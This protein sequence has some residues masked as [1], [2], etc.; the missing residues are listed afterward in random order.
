MSGEFFKTP[1]L[2]YDSHAHL[3]DKIFEGMLN[4][5]I[6]RARAAGVAGIM[7]PGDSLDSS[8]MAVQIAKRHP[9]FLRAAVGLHPYEARHYSDEVEQELEA[10]AADAVVA[11]IGEIGLDV[12]ADGSDPSP[13]D[14]QRR[15]FARQMELAKRLGL[16][17]VIHCRNA[18]SDLIELL[19]QHRIE[20]V[21]HCFSGTKSDALK[22]VELGYHIGFAGSLTF[23]NA[24]D[25]RETAAALPLERILIETDCPWL[26]PHPHRGVRPNEPAYVRYV[27]EMLASCRGTSFEEACRATYQNAARFFRLLK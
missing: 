18:Y 1:D 11:A 8:R 15:A 3:A 9:D 24:P 20:G 19:S 4:D 23:K 2:L 14:I 16:P 22:L 17:A 6:E 21:V 10:L 27:A 12:R 5:V 7:I 25:L 13:H 26:T